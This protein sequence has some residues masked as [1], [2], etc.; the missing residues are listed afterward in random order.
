MGLVW[1]EIPTEF[2]NTLGRPMSA[3]SV[4][5]RARVPGGWLVWTLMGIGAG[6][7]GGSTSGGLSFYP[8]PEHKWDV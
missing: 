1:E 8:D 3:Q 5:F 7:L 4:T 6:G 2:K